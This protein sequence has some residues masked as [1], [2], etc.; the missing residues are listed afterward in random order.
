M[1]TEEKAPDVSETDIVRKPLSAVTNRKRTRSPNT[2]KAVDGIMQNTPPRKKQKKTLSTKKSTVSKSK[3]KKSSKAT[4]TKQMTVIR[5][6]DIVRFA[7]DADDDD[8]DPDDIDKARKMK[9]SYIDSNGTV[10]VSLSDLFRVAFKYKIPRSNEIKTEFAKKLNV[11]L[12]QRG[13]REEDDEIDPDDTS[14]AATT[15]HGVHRRQIFSV[16]NGNLFISEKGFCILLELMWNYDDSNAY[17]EH[18]C[19]YRYYYRK[20]LF[21][22]KFKGIRVKK[23]QNEGLVLCNACFLDDVDQQFYEE[24]PCDCQCT[25]HLNCPVLKITEQDIKTDEDWFCPFCVG[26]KQ[27]LETLKARREYS[28][29]SGEFEVEKVLTYDEVDNEYFVKWKGYPA[30]ANCSVALS[31]SF[32]ELVRDFWKKEIAQKRAKKI[33]FNA[34]TSIDEISNGTND[35]EQAADPEGNIEQ[36]MKSLE[37]EQNA[38]S[39][40]NDNEEDEEEDEDVDVEMN[41]NNANAN[42]VEMKQSENEKANQMEDDNHN[43][44]DTEQKAEQREPVES[45]EQKTEAEQPP[46]FVPV[47]LVDIMDEKFIIPRQSYTHDT[48]ARF[49]ET[50]K[51]Y[52]KWLQS[53]VKKGTKLGRELQHEMTFNEDG[54]PVLPKFHLQS[55]HKDWDCSLPRIRDIIR[56]FLNRD[57]KQWGHRVSQNTFVIAEILDPENPAKKY[58]SAGV[59]EN[60]AYGLFATQF[61]QKDSLLFEYAGCVKP[62]GIASEKLD[63]LETELDQTTLFDLIGH[64]EEDRAK[65]FWGPRPND[66]LVIDPSRYHN[67]GVYM[68]DYRA[69]VMDD[70]DDDSDIDVEKSGDKKPIEGRRQNI[71]FYEV[72]VNNWPRVFAVALY[73]I[74]PGEELLTDYGADYWNNFRLMMRRQTQL[75]EIKDKIHAEWQQKFDALQSRFDVQQKEMEALKDKI[76]KLSAA[77]N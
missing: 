28:A 61:I 51:K 14:S 32:I 53:E 74:Q 62:I 15:V 18:W 76:A 33:P 49:K 12:L 21:G 13:I 59:H 41:D 52:A 6:S 11:Y 64:L 50:K 67:E 19:V 70:P 58:T 5:I 69:N 71:K 46:K 55:V 22:S 24:N 54:Q 56:E 65:L 72:L 37:I 27:S 77:K 45:A 8:N 38:N 1:S 39:N 36:Q 30:A 31:E 2:K 25:L 10:Y 63:H 34:Q 7:Q 68:N 73:D 29:K 3:K 16:F 48:F 40:N 43:R 23:P 44:H 26:T 47:E 60:K 4:S 57:W 17:I 66:Q 9:F 42:D 35:A 75:N 20:Q